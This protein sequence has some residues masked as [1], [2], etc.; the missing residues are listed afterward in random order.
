VDWIGL[1]QDGEKWRPVV[2]AVMN[3]QVLK[4]VG[5]LSS[6]CCILLKAQAEL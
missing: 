1:I 6:G 3:L 5:N 2:N 4:N